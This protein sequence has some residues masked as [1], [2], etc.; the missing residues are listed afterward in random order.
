MLDNLNFSL[1]QASTTN[2]KSTYEVHSIFSTVMDILGDFVNVLTYCTA[3][4]HLEITPLSY[5]SI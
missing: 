1:H 2:E 4:S 3:T 5:R